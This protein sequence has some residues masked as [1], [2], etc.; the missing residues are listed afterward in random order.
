MLLLLLAVYIGYNVLY[1]QN[2]DI[3]QFPWA[4]YN[5]AISLGFVDRINGNGDTD[6]FLR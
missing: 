5:T 6:D 4:Q 2:M 3:I 1:Y